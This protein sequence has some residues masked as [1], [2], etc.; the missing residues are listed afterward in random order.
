MYLTTN[1]LIKRG[2]KMD[3]IKRTSAV[4]AITGI[5]LFSVI[6]SFTGIASAEQ[7]MPEELFG[8]L[9]GGWA[10]NCTMTVG[11][12][13]T[14]DN[15]DYYTL[16]CPNE[17]YEQIGILVMAHGSPSVSW[18]TPV[19]AAVQN[20]CSPYPVELGFLEF[21]PNETI[22][23]AVDKLD[24]AGVTKIIAVP[25]FISSCSGHIAELEYVLGLR[26][27]LSEMSMMSTKHHANIR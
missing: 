21:V 3:R 25:L 17:D 4:V 9:S 7:M 14:G 1:D 15:P 5:V 20:V 12:E 22:N 16:I 11:E 6:V 26:E 8:N 24:E 27:D 18:C 19:R 13:I 2:D 23:V 10:F